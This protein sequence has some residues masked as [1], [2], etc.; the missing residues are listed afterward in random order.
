MSAMLVQYEQKVMDGQ[1]ECQE[2]HK[3]VRELEDQ[4]R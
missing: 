4:N 2:L 1:N 3:E